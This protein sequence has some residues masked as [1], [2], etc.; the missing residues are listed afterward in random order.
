M[1]YDFSTNK[2]CSHIIAFEDVVIDNGSII[3]DVPFNNNSVS[4]YFNGK[5][6]E[7][8][9]LWSTPECFIKRKNFK[10]DKFNN[11]L[12]YKLGSAYKTVTLSSGLF[13]QGDFVKMISKKTNELRFSIENDM[14]VIRLDD[15]LIGNYTLSFP[16]PLW[17][18]KSN[19]LPETQVILKTYN[20]LGILP[21]RVY[22][23][24]KLVPGWFLKKV[25]DG[26]LEKQAIVFDGEIKNS[27]PSVSVTYTT[28]VGYCKRCAGTGYEHDYSV[29]GSGQ[30]NVVKNIDLLTQEF[31][32]YLFTDIG[33]HWKWRWLGSNMNSLVGSK[34]LLGQSRSSID[35]SV[36]KAFE[37]YKSMKREQL[38]IYT[39]NVTD[40]EMP[41]S[42]ESVSVEQ[43]QNEPTA[44][45]VSI[46]VN[47]RSR[48]VI[49]VSKEI[50]IP[51]A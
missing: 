34:N 14:I 9:G 6:I 21:G 2:K 38:K 3:I 27:N 18:D 15:S 29:G 22:V 46:S 10:I 28:F 36:R 1:S 8:S 12:S 32:K 49:E 45:N 23:S 43:D 25:N 50:D 16:D 30:F 4:V 48:N 20:T 42:I 51:G 5:K 40:Y 41:T 17:I 39:Q 47:T 19:S 26:V 7:K 11:I 33:S 44:V 31:D 37:T 13:S 35:N 24:K